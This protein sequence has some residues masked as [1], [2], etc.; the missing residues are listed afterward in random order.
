[1]KSELSG[2]SNQIK[3]QT[4]IVHVK[5]SE[6]RILGDAI[7]LESWYT[8]FLPETIKTSNEQ[9]RLLYSFRNVMSGFSARL[10]EEVKAME[11]KEGFISA[12]PETILN[13]HTTHTPEYLG[14]N[15]QFGLWKD[16]NFGKGVII[17]VL[18]TG[19]SPDHPS[20]NDDGM[21][22]PPAKW[23]GRCEFG[24]SICNNKLIGARTFN[25][26]NSALM[27][28]SPIDENGHGTHT[29][30][31]AA[32]TFVEGAE[33]LGNARGKAVGMAPL[34]H[35]AMYKV[36]SPKGC[37][38]SDILAALDAAIHDGVDVLS[39]S[40]GAPSRPFYID[41]I[42]IG[43]FAAIKMGI[44]VS[45]SAGNSGPSKSTLANEAPWIL[46]VGAS[47][48]DRTIMA[49]ARLGNG[50]VHVGESLFQPRDFP[51]SFLP[52]VYAGSSGVK[53]SEFCVQGSL[54]NLNVKGKMVVCERGGGIGRIAKG[55]VVKNA[56]GAAMIIIN[57]K[58]DEFSTLAEAHIL[59]ATHVSYEAGLKIKSYIRSSQNPMASIS[60]E[61]TLIG[62]R[63]TTFSPAMASF[64]SRGPCLPSPGI[65]KPDITGPGVNILAAWPFSL[66]N[67]TNK[68][69]TFN[70]ISG[71][72]MSC[73]HLSGI[74]ALIKSVHPNWSPA[75]IK[76]AIMTS[77]DVRN[78]Q[79][80]PIVDQDLKPANFFAMG[81]GHV[82]PSKAAD[83]GLVYDIQPD[84]YIPYLCGLYSDA[85]VSII[86]RRKVTCSTISRIREGDLN[87]PSFAV[88][89]GPS[90]MFNRTVTN[91]GDANSI[92]SA[93]VEA[94]IG[95]S[96]KVTPNNLKF[97]RVI[98]KVTYSVTFSR[99][100]L[101]RT[102]SEFSEGYLIWVS[103]KHMVRSPISVKLK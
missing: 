58:A 102:T 12:R 68:K 59:P 90:Q 20:F 51:S 15:Q 80:R 39:L 60:F 25:R 21:P 88:T 6:L 37:S 9:S 33:A 31:T 18:D 65:L 41:N 81:S 83:P 76:S 4:Y 92:Y 86:V 75:A 38:S 98:E 55:M 100:D 99:D 50:E 11:E 36:C 103:N 89:L 53:G 49:L 28:E 27:G 72:S 54:T 23:K 34:A 61:G 94:P 1:M 43:A 40:L 22:Q 96:V 82:N 24:A 87:Y 14:L 95:V 62:S 45:C 17:G 93:I 7:D 64:S 84:D 13:L 66:D 69:S 79:G 56:G 74:A 32:G 46:T 73:P 52:L 48:I 63:A 16:S 97:S 10:T 78:R 67:N 71:T 8:S 101:V 3:L 85:Q 47:T 29:A 2:T 42:A 26:A 30:S 5:E 57:Q 70:V 35:L 91:V 77:A 19:I 44:F